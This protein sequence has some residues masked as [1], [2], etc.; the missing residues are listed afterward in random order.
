MTTIKLPKYYCK[1]CDYYTVKFNDYKKHINTNKHNINIKSMEKNSINYSIFYC[2]NCEY[3]TNSGKDYKKHLHSIKHSI[4]IGITTKSYICDYCNKEYKERSGLW[5]HKQICN[6]NETI[7]NKKNMES[8]KNNDTNISYL[9]LD[10]VKQNSEFKEIL[11]EQ[12]KQIM[13]LSKEK[14]MTN[15]NNT[16]N[17]NQFN[18][19]FFLNE[20]CKDAMNIN[21]FVE[22]LP[23]TINDL[24]ET[25]RL[26]F[27]EGITKIITRGLK[28]IELNKR[29]IHCSDA[30][31]E[32]LYIKENDK[33]EKDDTNKTKLETVVRKVGTKNIRMIAEWKKQYPDCDDYYS[34]KN[35]LYLKIV[36]NSMCGGTI[37]ETKN[38]YNKIKRN[39]IKHV[40][41]EK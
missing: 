5:R 26:G 18:L 12:N 32:T 19:Q 16:T 24:E 9:V 1:I 34:K 41:I 3:T 29:P 39:I 27:T 4:N 6:N 10:L 20:T 22:Q 40:I 31:R 8:N 35:D 36:N 14:T 38:N 25:G 2:N 7:E 11:L 33:W 21:E 15:C 23:V 17:N 28:E 37:E 30:K 13:E